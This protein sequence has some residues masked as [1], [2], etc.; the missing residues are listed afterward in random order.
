MLIY[1][2]DNFHI[3]ELTDD[4]A[5]AVTYA[6]PE[7]VPGAVNVKV[8]PKTESNPFF[9]D[10]GIYDVLT[11]LGD[12]DVEM[13]VADLPLA[14]QKKIYGRSEENG[15]QFGSADDRPINLALGF[16]AQTST[17]G[18]RYYYYLKGKPELLP[19]EAKTNEA[20]KTP[21]TAKVKIKFMPLLFNRRWF[22]V[23]EDSDTF[24]Q[25]DVWFDQVIYEGASLPPVV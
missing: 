8:D 2:L 15:V 16:R 22:S 20:S 3:A 7:R 9:A 1:G 24:T 6:V 11:N 25:G 4:T 10:N 19:V 14:L 23:A 18:Y 5:E 17:G 12:V 21:Q 13:E